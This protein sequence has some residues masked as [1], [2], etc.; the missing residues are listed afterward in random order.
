V[1]A[2]ANNSKW[3]FQH[4]FK[5]N[6]KGVLLRGIVDLQGQSR[7]LLK[8]FRYRRTEAVQ[9]LFLNKKDRRQQ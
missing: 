8:G 3:F 1:D 4:R 6:M 9:I 5:D 2:S 7:T